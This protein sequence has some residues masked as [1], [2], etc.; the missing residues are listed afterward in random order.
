MKNSSGT[1]QYQGPTQLSGT[2]NPLIEGSE[3]LS[4]PFLLAF[5]KGY[6][7][8][9]Q[10]RYLCGVHFGEAGKGLPGT[11]PGIRLGVHTSRPVIRND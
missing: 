1:Q 3:G 10:V 2:F 7:K 8:L 6:E 5:F 11:S 9:P 4:F